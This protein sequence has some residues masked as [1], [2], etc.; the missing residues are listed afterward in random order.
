MWWRD[1]RAARPWRGRTC[2]S[3]RRRRRAAARRAGTRQRERLG[4]V[5]AR[6]PQQ[7]RRGRGTTRTTESSV[8][9]WIGRS[10][11]RNT[12]AMPR[13]PLER[14]VVVVGD[15]LVGDVA[16]RHHERRAGVG[17]QQVVQRRVGQHHAELA[18]RRARPPAA[19]ARVRPAR[20]EHDRPLAARRAAPLVGVVELDERARG[21]EVGAPSARTACPRGACARAARAT[22]ASSSARQARW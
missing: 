12:S 21:R 19:T 7:Q 18:A 11:S 22:A 4:H 3:A 1:P 16:A 15:R 14:V 13:Q 5:A 10:W 8:R 20:R 2:S 9:V 6:A 17:E